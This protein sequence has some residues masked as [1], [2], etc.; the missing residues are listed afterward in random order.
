MQI[1]GRGKDKL[2]IWSAQD[3]VVLKWVAMQLHDI[4]PVHPLCE[5]HKGHGG[6]GRSVHRMARS[7]Q[8]AQWKY[9]CRTDIQ[10][11]YGHIRRG[12][13]MRQLKRHVSA[14]VLLNLV[15]QYL[16]YSVERGGEF[17]TPQKGICRGCA[18]SPLLAGFCLW[19]MD[20]YFEAQQPHLRY[21][22]FMDD[23]VILTRTR[24]HLRRVVRTL[25]VFFASGGYRQHPDKTFIG[26]TEKGFDW[27][28]IQFNRSGIEGVAPRA[29]AN[30]RQ[31][32]HRLYEQA[33]RY[34]IV[35]TRARV[36]EYVRRWKIWMMYMIKSLMKK[37]LIRMSDTACR[38]IPTFGICGRWRWIARGTACLGLIVSSYTY[39]DVPFCTGNG[40]WGPG[41][42]TG[43]AE[44]H[45]TIPHPMPAGERLAPGTPAGYVANSGFTRTLTCRM[46]SGTNRLFY[47]NGAFFSS[48]GNIVTKVS[49]GVYDWSNTGQPTYLQN[50]RYIAGS[51]V[52][53]CTGRDGTRTAVYPAD[54]V[55]VVGYA[56]DEISVPCVNRTDGTVT[57][58]LAVSPTTVAINNTGRLGASGDI[59]RTCT[60]SRALQCGGA[61][62][63]SGTSYGD[64]RYGNRDN[65][66][67]PILYQIKDDTSS[68][69]TQCSIQFPSTNTGQQTMDF[70]TLSVGQPVGLDQRWPGSVGQT[71]LVVAECTGATGISNRTGLVQIRGS[72][73]PGSSLILASDNP[74]VGFRFDSPS[75]D[76]RYSINGHSTDVG[77]LPQYDANTGTLTLSW[78]FVVSPV[79]TGLPA[80]PGK[81]K[82]FATIDLFP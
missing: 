74:G 71:G 54:A 52:L 57:I 19:S 44:I 33:W 56:A 10:G 47:A 45:L 11:F 82:A 13:L 38:R 62:V 17:Y 79:G 4:L 24:W 75:G 9:V 8:T 1:V 66:A 37:R 49:P 69:S 23:I 18:L 40:S 78:D 41:T 29:M 73:V 67:Y 5:H 12:P 2:A 28:G 43:T 63:A 20:T 31:R 36:G 70:G 50:L 59:A 6:G 80:L 32:L 30:H 7:L 16:H 3:A 14:P 61:I 76:A 77:V 25:N 15:R 55:S 39:A 35:K 34:G 64:W 42:S 53:S 27:L 60:V 65:R 68:S 51:A 48:A 58:S 26:K 72:G 46:A 81:T 22:R 21:V